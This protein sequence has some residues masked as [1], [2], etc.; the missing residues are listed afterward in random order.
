MKNRRKRSRFA[1]LLLAPVAVPLFLVG[2][3]LVEV[4]TEKG[5]GE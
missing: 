1:A 4:G 5:R 3:I 2:W